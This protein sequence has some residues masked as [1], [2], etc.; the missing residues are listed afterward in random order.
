MHHISESP[1]SILWSNPVPITHVRSLSEDLILTQNPIEKLMILWRMA[2][3]ILS[4]SPVQMARMHFQT[5]PTGMLERVSLKITGPFTIFK[6]ILY[7]LGWKQLL[8]E[9]WLLWGNFLKSLFL[10]SKKYSLPPDH[11]R[12]P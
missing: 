5:P 4:V 10:P 3:A 2:K 7:Q 12:I 6:A 9:I 11:L 1:E 8:L